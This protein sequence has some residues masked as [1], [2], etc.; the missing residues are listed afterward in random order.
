MCVCARV[1]VRVC[2]C[3]LNLLSTGAHAFITKSTETDVKLSGHR[4]CHWLCRS[5]VQDGLRAWLF[6]FSPLSLPIPSQIPPLCGFLNLPF[7]SSFTLRILSPFPTLLLLCP[8]LPPFPCPFPP[9]S[10]STIGSNLRMQ[11][12]PLNYLTL[13]LT[14][15][16]NSFK[17]VDN[18]FNLRASFRVRSELILKLQD[19]TSLVNSAGEYNKTVNNLVSAWWNSSHEWCRIHYCLLQVPFHKILQR[20]DNSDYHNLQSCLPL[21][22]N[23]QRPRWD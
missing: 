19:F 1:R 10:L 7:P 14:H 8:P 20:M 4:A 16:A 6:P 12:H 17:A 9:P 21:P 22:R 23:S 18:F 11:L 3:V 2:V 13:G 5:K 15:F